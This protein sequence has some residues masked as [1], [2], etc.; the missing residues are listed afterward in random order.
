MSQYEIISQDLSEQ[1]T[2]KKQVGRLRPELASM[3]KVGCHK[4]RVRAYL[5]GK[6]IFPITLELDLTSE[7]TRV[8]PECPSATAANH[9]SLNK[10]FVDRLFGYLV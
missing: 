8:C 10:E 6:A 4:E 2:G 9:H 1:G 3:F 5:D 7:C